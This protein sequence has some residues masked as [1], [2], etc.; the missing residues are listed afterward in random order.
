MAS[1][2]NSWQ[3]KL[4]DHCLNFRLEQPRW[5]DV[6]DR[7]GGRTAWSSIVVIQG[8]QIAARYWYDGRYVE[9]A[10]E[11]AAE[12][13]LQMLGAAPVRSPTQPYGSFE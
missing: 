2:P 13:A 4:R 8:R 7:R 3:D 11:D 1:R 5:Q 12:V 9:Q 6:S 10:R